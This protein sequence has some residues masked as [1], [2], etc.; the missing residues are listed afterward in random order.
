[1]AF[2]D[3]LKSKPATPPTPSAPT[4][5]P[6]PSVPA[7]ASDTF[8]KLSETLDTEGDASARHRLW[9]ATF[10]L[11]QW[12]FIDFAPKGAAV[13]SPMLSSHNGRSCVLVY[14]SHERARI[15]ERH[16]RQSVP[17]IDFAVTSLPRSAALERICAL[18][19]EKP[20]FALFNA[21]TGGNGF[22]ESIPSLAA[23]SDFFLD[24]L[25]NGALHR[26]AQMAASAPDPTPMTRLLRRLGKLDAWYFIADS[27]HKDIPQ[28][29]TVKNV[30]HFAVY[31]SPA[32]RAAFL[33]AAPHLA[34]RA[35]FQLSPLQA[36]A[37]LQACEKKTNH[38]LPLAAF[39]PGPHFFAL[40]I[41]SLTT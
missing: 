39:N 29:L 15:A 32:D 24:E 8:T 10:A 3:F 37:L 4:P 13:L 25:P 18:P 27:D 14:T 9:T 7:Q 31:T 30:N 11:D 17:N 12:H 6:I 20:E 22:A 19:T 36:T 5:P 1:M 38:Q 26:L 33:A 2:F 40:P 35:Q 28:V 21:G 16:Y 23:M 34:T 41:A